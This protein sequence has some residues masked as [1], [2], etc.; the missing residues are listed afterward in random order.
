MVLGGWEIPVIWE[1]RKM[2]LD[3]DTQA[4]GKERTTEEIKKAM[5]SLVHFLEFTG[6]SA[7]MFTNQRFPTLDVELWWEGGKEMHSFYEKPQVP[8]RVLL[9]GTALPESTVRATLIQETVRRM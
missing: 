7:S 8:N 2:D 1:R 4:T 6:E 9:K 5:C 3:L